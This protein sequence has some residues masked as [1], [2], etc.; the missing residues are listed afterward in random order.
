MKKITMICTLKSGAVVKDYVKFKKSDTYAI[1]VIDA[2]QKAV[3][4]SVGYSEPVAQN[5]IV[6]TTI[7]ATS[8]IAAITFREN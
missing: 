8:E 7:V 1:T 2:L 6:G 5:I 4:K 3:N